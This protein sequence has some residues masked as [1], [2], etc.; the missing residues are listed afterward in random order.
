MARLGMYTGEQVVKAFKRDGWVVRNQTGSHII[1]EKENRP[2]TLSV[3]SHKGKTVKRGTL[4]DQ[5]VD[6]GLKPEEF[7][8]LV[9]GKRRKGTT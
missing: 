9:K 5:I 2:H 1:M 8:R 6:A 3:P 7:V 4:S